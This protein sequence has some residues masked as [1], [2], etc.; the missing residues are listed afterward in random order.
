MTNITKFATIYAR[1]VER[2]GSESH[3]N[4]LINAPLPN[5]KLAAMAED[6]FLAEM[7][8]C[9]TRAGFSWKVI[10]RKWPEFEAAFFGFKVDTLVMLSDEQ[11]EAYLE[12]TRIVRSWQ[13]IKALK[14]NA[15]FFYDLRYENTPMP[16]LIANWP[17]SD[18]IGLLQFFKKRG[19]R[20]GG[21]T[22]QYFLRRMG[23]DGFVLGRD[24]VLALQS[25]GLDIKDEPSSQREMKLIQAAFNQWHEESGL[26]YMQLSQ[27]AAYSN[28]DNIVGV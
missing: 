22:G 7:T 15:L 17:E 5:A 18:Q 3:L 21:N 24:V 4:A 12:D 25:A 27:I 11:W 19:S 14:E 2:K 1:A 8:R 28:G 10:N 26:P 16:T 13:K 20:L 9:V 6:R 23:K